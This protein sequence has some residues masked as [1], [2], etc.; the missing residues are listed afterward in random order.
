MKTQGPHLTVV[1][2]LH[3]SK[4]VARELLH[5]EMAKAKFELLLTVI[6]Y[7]WQLIH[8]GEN[9]SGKTKIFLY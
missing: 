9:A 1:A 7:D 8:R 2:T 4:N 6:H 3:Y 5:V